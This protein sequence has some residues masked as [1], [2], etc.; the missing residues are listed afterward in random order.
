MTSNSFSRSLLVALLPLMLGGIA[1]AQAKPAAPAQQP[2][3]GYEKSLARYKEL[4][5]RLPF[6][7]HTEGR[8]TLAQTRAPEAFRILA[9]EYTKT[10]D[11]TE[12]ARY[13]LG[14]L[15]GRH[16]TKSEFV[17]GLDALRK[18]NSKPADAWLWIKALRIKV[19]AVG[20]AE[21]VEIAQT[22][23]NVVH[24]ASAIAAIGES[25]NGNLKAVVLPTCAD[26]PKKEYERYMLLGA[27]SGALLDNKRRVN[28]ADYRD[29]LT[30]YIGLLADEIDLP[31]TAKIQMAR[32]LQ[33]ILG[34]PSLYINQQPWLDI[35]KSGDVKVQSKP[36]HTVVAPR[37]FGIETEGERFCYVID[38]SDSMLSPISPSAKPQEAGGPVTGPRQAPAKKK[39]RELLD[40]ND[41]P[42]DK[43]KNRWDLARENLKIALM[44]LTPDKHFAVVWFGDTS[45]TLD[46]C[47]GM[48]KAT[49]G[50]V[51]RV[52]AELDSIKPT[53]PGPPENGHP[54]KQGWGPDK[55]VLRGNTNMHSG[56][57][58][59]F[60]L[61]GRGFV[62]QMA[63][64]DPEALTEGCD[65]IFL[66]SDGAPTTDDFEIADKDYGEGTP[67]ESYETGK[68]AQR[69]PRMW[70]P[71]PYA[72]DDWLIEDVRR[73]N[74]FRRIRIHCVGLGEANESLLKSLAAIG[75]GEWQIFGKPKNEPADSDGKK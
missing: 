70:Y 58:R 39:K 11:Y 44:R 1:P 3:S 22:N 7:Y 75:N 6:Q 14:T 55:K 5:S 31:H 34:G 13:T 33:L 37:F 73:M 51:D 74:A 65:T 71:G 38:M 24:R 45:G 26:F 53:D 64:V 2:P 35:L 47:K 42:W 32:H 48:I 16:F 10:Q 9:E 69:T 56:L 27:M 17:E 20:D 62:D 21:A 49:K 30:A 46:S 41:L 61:A 59:A 72:H 15:F 25:R 40:E 50:N 19:D 68:V 54:Q 23:K 29:A 63:Y 66:L 36:T 43:I 67:V 4:M 28:D 8:D 18:V 60:G 57:R 52:C 12:Y